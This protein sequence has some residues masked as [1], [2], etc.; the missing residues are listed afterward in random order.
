MEFLKNQQISAGKSESFDRESK[1]FQENA[2]K[3]HNIKANNKMFE[4]I[5]GFQ[6]KS[7]DF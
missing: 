6:R 2:R 3:S 1:D 4:I 5:E 7:K